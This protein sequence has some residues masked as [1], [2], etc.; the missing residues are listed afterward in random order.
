M[1]TPRAVWPPL[2]TDTRAVACLPWAAGAITVTTSQTRGRASSKS[3]RSD[4]VRPAKPRGTGRRA[5]T[6]AGSGARAARDVPRAD[7][8]GEL[9]KPARADCAGLVVDEQVRR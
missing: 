8:V 1:H 9:R 3:W 2:P 5:R 6:R 4:D 7:R